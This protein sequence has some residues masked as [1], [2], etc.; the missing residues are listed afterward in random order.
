MNQVT[1]QGQAVSVAF[2]GQYDQETKQVDVSGNL[3][4]ASFLSRVDR[5]NPTG[6]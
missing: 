2:V 5:C 3:V 6:G 4:P 1:G